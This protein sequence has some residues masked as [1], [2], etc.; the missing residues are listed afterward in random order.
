MELNEENLLKALEKVDEPDLKQ[1]IVSLDL[2]SDI[3]IEDNKISFQVKV[4][5]PAMHARKRMEEA[6]DFAIERAFGKEVK[7]EIKVKGIPQEERSEEQREVLPGV[8]NIV[9]VASGKGGVGKS[10]VTANLA[11]S[12]AQ[13][14]YK[15]GLIDADIYGPSVPTM[16]DLQ[17]AKP[18]AKDVN[19]KQLIEPLENHGVKVLSIGFFADADQAIV[20]RGPMATK[21]VDQLFKDVD[22]GELDHLLIDVPPGT[23]DIHLTLVQTAP[24]TGAIITSTPQEVALSDAKKGVNMFR[25]D[26]VGVPVLGMIENMAYFTPEELPENK[27]YIFGKEGAK[28]LSEQMNVPFLGEIPLVQSIR[29]AGDVGR[30]AALQ[31][32]TPTAEAFDKLC[33]AYIE[34][35]ERRNREQAPT[36]RVEVK[37]QYPTEQG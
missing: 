7:T 10:T 6:C 17:E 8:K 29:E 19:G 36:E 25:L 18:T 3:T 21:A 26:S 13:K 16:F 27:Y 20:W 32:N 30:P 22:W 31:E 5:N 33:D 28:R 1:D 2:V 15:V 12:L 14:G 11:V 35:V 37:Q 24:L 34:E 9:A 4:K 23:G